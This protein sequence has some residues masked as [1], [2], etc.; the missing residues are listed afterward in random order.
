MD[1]KETNKTLNIIE[2][3]TEDF[4]VYANAVIKSR[5]ISRSEDNLKPVHRRILYGMATD[6]DLYSNK[7]HK[8][9][10]KIV[11]AIM[12]S[13][14]PHGDSS[15]YDAM[16]RLAQ[17]W[18]MRYPLVEV[19]GNFG[20]ILGDGAA[21]SRYT[22]AKLSPFGDMM[23]E[24]IK[25]RG[26]PFRANYDET[27]EEPVILPSVFPNILCNGNAGIAVGFSSSLVPHNLKEVVNAIIAYLDFKGITTNGLM[28][29][30]LGPDFP[31]GGTIVDSEK[32]AEIYE[33]GAGTIKLRSKYTIETVRNQTHIIIHEVPYL[34]N[35]EDGILDS[36]KKLILEDGFD[37]IDEVENNTG[38]NG[39]SLRIILKKGANLY[40]VLDTLW[41]KTRLQTT[42]RISNTV[43]VDG[44]PQ[45]LGLKQLI[46]EYVKHRHNVIINIANFDLQ[47]IEERLHIVEGLLK[48]LAQIDPIIKLIKESNSKA[49]AR[50]KIIQ[51]LDVTEIQ[52]NAILDMK[53]SR[54]S[55]LDGVE[56]TAEREDLQKQKKVLIELISTPAKRELQMRQELLRISNRYGD[57]RRTA[58]SMVGESAIENSEI[59]KLNIL[60]LEDGK[61]FATQQDLKKL[62]TKRRNSPLNGAAIKVAIST[63]TDK[64][65]G[66]FCAD[67][68]IVHLKPLMLSR[69]EVESGLLP[70]TPLAALELAQ[71]A[72]NLPK[73]TIFCSSGGLLK[74]TPTSE[75]INA[76]NGSRTT[77][78][79][80]DQTLIFVGFGNDDDH[81]AV[82]D[83]KLNVFPVGSFAAQSKLTL[84]SKAIST[85]N[86]KSIAILS[87]NSEI[88]M[89]NNKGQGKLTKVSELV[90]GIR[91]G[92]GQVVA[93]NTSLVAAVGTAYYIYDIKNNLI[94]ENP[95]IKAK[96]A[97]GAKIIS[98]APKSITV[99]K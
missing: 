22:E 20:N 56:L 66:V 84:G 60:L 8:K 55:K 94:T 17:P 39:I 19:Q 5:A 26:V 27:T 63:T 77:K 18:K 4:L 96:T 21:A 88:L 65:I 46:A 70:S 37:L 58:L 1:N 86:V 33:T 48:A 3:S 23:L 16:I 35:I 90:V 28:K 68:T 49:D 67:G 11:G 38:Q 40:K 87:P 62:D 29:H 69:E 71:D 64:T 51:F 31:T 99:L 42:Q 83:E 36:I 76:K 50:I 52:A 14:H 78:L 85:G 72:S 53:L 61:V 44:K 59:E 2:K 91:G 13:Y 10:A 97:V 93:E 74:R 47:K 41:A 81:V 12:G 32:L 73:Y 9:S 7:K 95:S 34:V 92:V 57:A 25:K 30:I 80:N 82:L 98:G 79:K 75:Y 89:L 45:V 24:G 54:L 43:I 6:L 15:I